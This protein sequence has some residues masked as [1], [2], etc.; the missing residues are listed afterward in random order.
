MVS[1]RRCLHALYWQYLSPQ[2]VS[3]MREQGQ[4]GEAGPAGV[5]RP[6]G[7]EGCLHVQ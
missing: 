4:P 6:A 7:S 3:Q 2:G 5:Q 1:L